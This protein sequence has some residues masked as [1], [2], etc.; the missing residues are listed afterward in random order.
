MRIPALLI[1]L[2]AGLGACRN[3]D[4]RQPRESGPAQIV[5]IVVRTDPPGAQ[6]RVGR[7]SK[8]WTTPCDIADYAITKG[9]HD[10]EVSLLGYQT[11]T[12]KAKY[13]GYDPVI[14]E[15][16]LSRNA[17][18]AAVVEPA[19]PPAP[20]PVP[21]PAPAPAPRP[22]VEVPAAPPVVQSEP[23]KGG[24]RIRIT[25]VSGRVRLKAPSV[26]TDVDKPGEF[27]VPNAPSGRVILEF[28]DQKTDAVIQSVEYS[29][30]GELPAGA[31]A[32]D[33]ATP[34]ADRVGEVK[35][36]SKTYGV[37]VKLDPGLMLQPGEEIL[38]YRDG[39]EVARTKIL[40]VTKADAAYP[41][42]A[43]QVQKE[44]A[45]QKGDEVRRQKP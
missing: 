38:V 25:P 19:P 45:I 32:P 3:F 33:P 12:T 36:V 24:L 2:V 10:V 1:L 7:G 20:V 11:V 43:A 22:V 8:T 37:F 4:P 14:L 15:L 21:A 35:V 41:D 17:G 5:S 26:I 9:T 31:K 29:Q 40:K 42:G 44:S 13:D 16:K 30:V 34:E 39:R 28:L 27:F 6:V 23:A 18:A